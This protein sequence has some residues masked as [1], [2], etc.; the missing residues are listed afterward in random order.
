M[1]SSLVSFVYTDGTYS[2]SVK[3][4]EFYEREAMEDQDLVVL[5][6]P[7]KLKALAPAR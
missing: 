7:G 3:G 2:I 5:P 4:V 1:S 6:S